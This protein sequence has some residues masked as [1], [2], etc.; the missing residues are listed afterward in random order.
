MKVSERRTDLLVQVAAF[1]QQAPPLLRR[2]MADRL[3]AILLAEQPS[4]SKKHPSAPGNG[5]DLVPCSTCGERVRRN[6]LTRH[7]R[8]T[9]RRRVRTSRAA[10]KKRWKY[11]QK[12]RHWVLAAYYETHRCRQAGNSV[13]CVQG[14]APG[15]GRRR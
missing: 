4:R 9:H 1:A 2:Q 14:G 6:K 8:R 10:G 15:L 5:T 12:G 3:S 11:C 7:I 13:R